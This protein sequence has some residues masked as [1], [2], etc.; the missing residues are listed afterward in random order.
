MRQ[1]LITP[2]TGEPK[3]RVNPTMIARFRLWLLPLLVA[4][5]L[6]LCGSREA[7]AQTV[8]IGQIIEVPYYFCPFGYLDTNGS[9]LPIANNQALFSLLGT[10]YGGDG[11][12]NFAL[13]YIPPKTLSTGAT[14]RT[15]IA[16]IG[17]YPSR[18]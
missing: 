6:T 9:L 4:C 10:T 13:P 5:G 8:F 11:V 18:D 15:C 3:A 12:T 14:I 16:I 2:F 1:E 7:N 17:V